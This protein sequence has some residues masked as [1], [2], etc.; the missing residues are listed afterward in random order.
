MDDALAAHLDPVS[1]QS[2]MTF[3]QQSGAIGDHWQG[4]IWGCAF[5]DLAV[6]AV[7]GVNLV[8]DYLRRRAWNEKPMNKAYMTA[9]RDARMS[10]Y[11]VSDVV[12][13]EP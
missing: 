10:V 5:E 8:D 3:Q 7:A 11:E 1:E 6:Q 4:P 12:P 9:L 2:G 13:G